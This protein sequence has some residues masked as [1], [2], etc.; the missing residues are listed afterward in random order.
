MRLLFEESASNVYKKED[1][2]RTLE[3]LMTLTHVT[4][5][6]GYYLFTKGLVKV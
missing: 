4:T 5:G 2:Y 6:N 3:K 1:T